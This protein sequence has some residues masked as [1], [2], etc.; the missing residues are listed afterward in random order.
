MDL[1]KV[2]DNAALI[3]RKDH[4]LP[5][6]LIRYTADVRKCNRLYGAS[7]ADYSE[8]RF[9]EK[10][11]EERETYFTT[12]HAL[13]F[14]N[15]VNG[16]EN[17]FR[18]Y[19]KCS[20]YRIVGKFTKREQLFCQP[21]DYK[22]F[23]DYFRRHRE[24]FYKR[25]DK[26]CGNGIELW[27]ADRTP[28]A[29]LYERAARYSA[30]LD[31]PVVQHPDLARLNPDTLNTVKIYTMMLKDECRFIAAELRMGRRGSLVD[32]IE[33]GGLGAAVDIGTGTVMG[34]AYDLQMDTYPVHPDTGVRIC[35]FKLP[36]WAEV[37][38]FTE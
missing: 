27:S 12:D 38:R 5:W 30:V 24:A 13:R 9:F 36:N 32:N 15:L 6:E 10:T 29:E 18:F 16:I 2:R 17:N 3:L 21:K 28:L 1:Q 7:I 31:E 26:Y 11:P 22:E 23:E 33:R 20:M 37:I 19:D 4:I 14:I 34:E 8:L 25:N 35:D